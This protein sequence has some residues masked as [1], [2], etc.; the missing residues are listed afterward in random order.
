MPNLLINFNSKDA[1]KFY[2]KR[3][4]EI[5]RIFKKTALMKEQNF[6][7]YITFAYEYSDLIHYGVYGFNSQFIPKNIFS[8]INKSNSPM[9]FKS[10]FKL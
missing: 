9:S 2:Q 4:K 10:Y 7:G 6:R 3:K 5:N 8:F 1:K